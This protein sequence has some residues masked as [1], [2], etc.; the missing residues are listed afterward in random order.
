MSS[1][2]SQGYHSPRREPRQELSLRSEPRIVHQEGRIPFPESANFEELTTRALEMA[3][4]VGGVFAVP[5]RHLADWRPME[6]L[7]HEQER[8][9]SYKRLAYIAHIYGMSRS[10]RGEWYRIGEAIPLSDRCAVHIISKA[11]RCGMA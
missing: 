6:H 4:E 8:G 5:L 11:K 1:V 7:A 2:P 9:A 10:E 3:A